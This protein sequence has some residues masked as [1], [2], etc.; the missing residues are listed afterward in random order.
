MAE[1]ADSG[2]D[3]CHVVLV[4]GVDH[5]LVADGASGLNDRRRA[6]FGDDFYSVGK[7][8]EGVGCGDTAL[9]GEYGFHGTDLGGIDAA[10]LA[11]ADAD[12]L[13]VLGVENC[14][15]LHVLADFPG[16]KKVA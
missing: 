3:H 2:E 9:E 16:E 6:G 15:G 1:V 10:H 11:C 5:I 12:T 4:R 14:V 7:W 13:A 8:E